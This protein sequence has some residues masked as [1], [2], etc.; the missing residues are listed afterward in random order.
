MLVLDIPEREAFDETTLTFIKINHCTLQMEHSL[1]SLS[2]WESKYKKPFINKTGLTREETLY[3]YK[4]MTLTPKVPDELYYILTREEMKLIDDYI[5]DS[6]TASTVKNDVQEGVA[7]NSDQFITSE[8]I[9]SWLALNKIPF[10]PCEKWHLSR[11][12][13]LIQMVAE[14]RAP[15]DSKKKSKKTP[16]QRASE[17]AAMNRARKAK[18]GVKG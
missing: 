16:G 5:C 10:E 1:I 6:Q 14:Q 3:Y 17:Y 4:C 18:Y 11:T 7:K 12:L 15:K 9:Y 8:L 13:I 2:K